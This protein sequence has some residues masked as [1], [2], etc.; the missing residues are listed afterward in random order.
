MNAPQESAVHSISTPLSADAAL[1]FNHGGLFQHRPHFVQQH[2]VATMSSDSYY[3]SAPSTSSATASSSG[4]SGPRRRNAL[5][6]DE[7]YE[8]IAETSQ[9]RQKKSV[10]KS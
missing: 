5:N 8:L 7:H 9:R 6:A 1:N 2:S 10:G 4:S 3:N